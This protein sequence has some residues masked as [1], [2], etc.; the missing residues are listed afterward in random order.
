MSSG[1]AT[2]DTDLAKLAATGDDRAFSEL[3]RRHKDPLFRL[4]RR[5]AGNPDDAYEAVQEAFISAWSALDRYDASRPF[6]AWLRTIAINKARDRSRRAAVRRLIFSSKSVDDAQA[7][8]VHDVSIAPEQILTD[9]EDARR[10]ELAISRLPANL[11]EPLLLTAFDGNS[12]QAAADIL[13]VSVK[14]IET[15]VARARKKLS[16]Q[17]GGRLL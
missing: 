9:G 3:V 16:E 5:Y 8:A 14:T 1:E 12:Q 2:S 11:K 15:R 13:R 10:L 6:G 4:L 7:M 17:L